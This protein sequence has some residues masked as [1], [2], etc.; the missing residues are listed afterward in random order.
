[1]FAHISVY[2]SLL[3]ISEEDIKNGNISYREP[4]PAQ[5]VAILCLLGA[6]YT[7]SVWDTIKNSL[8]STWGI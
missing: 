1:L 6:D 5:I 7:D 2:W 3:E 8:N 4:N